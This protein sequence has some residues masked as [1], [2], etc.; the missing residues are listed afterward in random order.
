MDGHNHLHGEGGPEARLVTRYGGPVQVSLRTEPQ[1]PR[2][3]SAF[4]IIYSLKDTDG[5]PIT[6]D[7]LVMSHERLMHLVV[8]SRDL[9]F[10]SHIHPSDIQGGDYSFSDTWPTE[11][12]Y[13]LFNEFITAH[14]GTQ[15][16]R[17]ELTL[18][19][20]TNTGT[21][22][23][24][25]DG[26]RPGDTRQVDGLTVSLK[27]QPQKIRRR[28]PARFTLTVSAGGRPVTTLEPYLGAPAHV[29]IVST[30]TTQFVHTHADAGQVAPA[31]SGDGTGAGS[32]AGSEHH[33]AM[34]MGM[35]TTQPAGFGPDI[36]FT[37]TFMQAGSYKMWVQFGYAGR[38]I[39]VPCSITV[40]K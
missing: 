1:N 15:L 40:V 33:H 27:S 20:S 38:V 19:T 28:A 8:V 30:D 25:L 37:H 5:R 18:G 32:G 4:R 31:G 24:S 17:H 10:F 6:P 39:T 21:P 34:G 16:E 14:G 13:V 26:M 7:R 11:G 12:Q 3:L 36:T 9:S 29:V 35:G 22:V 23:V 2:P